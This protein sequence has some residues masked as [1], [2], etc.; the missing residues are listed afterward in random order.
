[1]P[2]G[3]K[4]RCAP[5]GW[6]RWRAQSSSRQPARLAAVIR[7]HHGTFSTAIHHPYSSTK[8]YPAAEC[9]GRRAGSASFGPQA[10]AG[11]GPP[12]TPMRPLDEG[13]WGG[14]GACPR[15][16]GGCATPCERLQWP[17]PWLAS[18]REIACSSP[19]Q[20]TRGE[21]YGP[22]RPSGSQ[23]VSCDLA[24]STSWPPWASLR[25]R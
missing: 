19:H 6:R 3:G 20:T 21:W 18:H 14:R 9:R 16:R 4:G 25:R 7:P 23:P 24:G 8:G 15:R 5:A 12:A 1:M 22:T 17:W 2:A 10:G 13:G 11:R